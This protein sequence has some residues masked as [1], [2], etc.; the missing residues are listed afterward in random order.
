MEQPTT[1]TWYPVVGYEGYYEVS[2]HRRV[3][4]L[5]RRVKRPQGG[6]NLRKGKILKLSVGPHGGPVAEL[7]KDAKRRSRTVESLYREAVGLDKYARVCTTC[8]KC[9]SRRFGRLSGPIYCSEDCRPRCA[10]DGCESPKRKMEWCQK[11]H[12][13]WERHGDPNATLVNPWTSEWV[14]VV[15]GVD[16]PRGSGRRKHCSINCQAIDS[17]L[18]G[19]IPKVSQCGVC[20]TEINLLERNYNGRKKRMDARYCDK[21]ARVNNREWTRHAD[22][23][24]ERDNSTCGICNMPVDDTKPYPHPQSLTID[25]IIP[26]SLGGGNEIDNLQLAHA[27]CNSTKQDRIGFTIA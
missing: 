21:C 2:D 12:A 25:H 17:R 16:V 27:V 1:E 19:N 7:S 4:S 6:T 13:T 9:F 22:L 3:R 14:C 26:R 8:G 24:I 10:V 15:C 5:P 18:K 20:G 23:L 11:H